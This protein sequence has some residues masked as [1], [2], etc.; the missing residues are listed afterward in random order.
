MEA[1]KLT[2]LHRLS[3]LK[4]VTIICQELLCFLLV[5]GWAHPFKM[6]MFFIKCL[7]GELSKDMQPTGS[8]LRL[9]K[10]P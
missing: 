7:P 8:H 3:N 1:P 9:G 2:L 4:P 10:C 6:S 5:V